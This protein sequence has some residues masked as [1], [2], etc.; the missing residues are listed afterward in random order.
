MA[1]YWNRLCDHLNEA[2][3][4]EARLLG[5]EYERLCAYAR[6][7][8][9]RIEQYNPS[10]SQSSGD[11]DSPH[12]DPALRRE[13]LLREHRETWRTAIAL[14]TT[15]RKDPSVAATIR[16]LW[17]R[18]ERDIRLSG[19]SSGC[20][21]TNRASIANGFRRAVARLRNGAGPP[22]KKYVDAQGG[23][24]TASIN[25]IAL[26]HRF[27]SGGLQASQSFARADGLLHFETVPEE[28]YMSSARRARYDRLTTGRLRL[29]TGTASESRSLLEIP[30]SVVLHRP[31]PADGVI[32]VVQLIGRRSFGAWSWRLNI[33]L[34]QPPPAS[35]PRLGNRPVAGLDLNWRHIEG[36]L[37]ERSIRFGAVVDSAGERYFLTLPLVRQSQ[38]GSPQRGR[39][40]RDY[41]HLTDLQR[42]VD[43]LLEAT[44]VRVKGLVADHPEL[45]DPIVEWLANLQYAGR[46]RLVEGLSL[47]E[48]YQV[49]AAARAL[50][51]SNWLPEDQRM[52][53]RIL[54]LS[55]HLT[56]RRT[57]LYRNLALALCRRYRVIAIKG[58]FSVSRV[59]RQARIWVLADGP[60]ARSRALMEGG[61]YRQWA[62]IQTFVQYLEEAAR[63]CRTE[64]LKG[65]G[66][67]VTVRHERCGNLVPRGPDIDLYCQ[68]CAIQF[69]QDINAG[70]NLL[71]LI[72]SKAPQPV[73]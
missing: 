32:K 64:I 52:R 66:A 58:D 7:L 33:T 63:K 39:R 43:N 56:N 38:Q 26:G 36:P 57:H 5:A 47:L 13:E 70:Q 24:N 15:R 9:E 12:G 53:R 25:R 48:K 65:T 19:I 54:R 21:E 6:V 34:E 51:R 18:Y 22:R 10:L 2:W 20:H 11:V 35:A 49:A 68:V 27:G 40:F 29:R 73:S 46:R 71:A 61:V 16:A 17:D 41:A 59:S 42:A 30:F 50:L 14:R 72:P 62:A 8:R 60:G 28:A 23:I 4:E 69:D 3:Q 37:G 1:A 31:L 44:K 55:E 67:F 45:P